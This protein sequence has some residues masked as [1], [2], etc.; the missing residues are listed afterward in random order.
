MFVRNVRKHAESL[1]KRIAQFTLSWET[2]GVTRIRIPLEFTII[3]VAITV[4]I[5][6]S[7]SRIVWIEL[8]VELP[9]S[10]HSVIIVVLVVNFRTIVPLI[11]IGVIGNWIGTVLLLFE[12]GVVFEVV[13]E[14]LSVWRVGV[15]I[16]IGI[17]AV[18]IP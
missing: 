2:C 1:S 6:H 4:G 10:G 5:D 18:V 12:V 9:S 7:V 3:H 16:T 11:A 14:P 13:V 17:G 15:N 8:E